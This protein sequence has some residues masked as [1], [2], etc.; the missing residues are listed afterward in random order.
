MKKRI[1]AFLLAVS[2]AVSMLAMP[3][4][5]VQNNTAVQM[6]LTL[7]AMDNAQ[8]T[9]LNAPVTRGAFARMLTAFSNYRD[10]V[11]AQG[12]VGTLFADVPSDSANAPYV[13]IAVQNGWMN[14]YTDGSFRPDNAVTLEEACT[15][16]LKLLGYKM[17]E[18]SG[19]FPQAQLNK[20][21]QLGLRTNLNCGQGQPMNYQDCSVLLYN[22][23]TANTSGGGSYGASLGFTVTD[24]QVDPSSV[25]MASLK[26]PF[27]AAEGAVL[28][29]E[30]LTVYRNDKA[31]SSAQLDP[32][33]VY[34]YSE[35]LQSVWIY[36]RRAAGRI[37]AVSPS[38]SAPTSVTVA[39]V[40]YQIGSADVAAQI[41]SLNGG[42]V[43]EVVTLLL[44]MNNVAAGIVT[45]AAA[46]DVYYGVVSSASRSL[47]EENGADVLQ[48]VSVVCTDGIT[49][50]VRVDKSMNFPKSWLVEVRVTPEG[51]TVT[52]IANK[53]L[54]GKFD[55][56]NSMLGSTPLADDVEIL[57]TTTGGAAGTVRPSR[58]SGVNLN[59][60][61]VRYYTLNEK[62][63]IDRLI[64]NDVTGDLW[65]YGVL[66]DIQTVAGNWS[67]VSALVDALV[68][69]KAPEKDETPL[70][71][72][73]AGVLVPTTSEILWGV[74]N[75]TLA[76]TLWEK[77]TTNTG[78]LLSIGIRQLAQLTG[79]PFSTLLDFMGQGAYY[80]CYVNGQPAAYSTSIKYPVIAG[81]V[82]VSQESNGSVANMAQL[83]PLKID[84]IGAATV[85]SGSKRVELADMPQVY[86]WYKGQ[87]YP[88]KLSAVNSE[89]YTL[90]GWYDNFG[91]AAGKKV[92]VI[93]AVKKD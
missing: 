49:R 71:D 37:T 79:T 81:G 65:K 47:V 58:L 52:G 80:I 46:D 10:S 92:R 67:Q 13:R 12:T 28:P 26:G 91:A 35:S 72:Q 1:L 45:G 64:L 83:M 53:S 29:F 38:A 31:S 57:D 6:A 23:L 44:G 75:G 78:P 85:Q 73:V 36:T 70:G 25:M 63:Q 34:Y 41:S 54:S 7:G 5:A 9:Q 21:S 27:I 60:L 17:T 33:D 42:G 61:D 2:I 51:E 86:L 19:A 89:D 48:T 14:G 30:P 11:S 56:E 16:V 62:G 88:T 59:G 69:N 68:N 87:Y 77:L 90:T 24:G 4:A 20:A 40:P 43:G 76:D 15:A 93:I 22:A 39:G 3:A 74:V 8:T 50:S 82:A 66:N 32:Y 55:L 84:K 18:L